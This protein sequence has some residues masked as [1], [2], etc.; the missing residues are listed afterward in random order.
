[1]AVLKQKKPD[2]I[3]IDYWATRE[4]TGKE[5]K[6]LD[7][8]NE[9]VTVEEMRIIDKQA[10]EKYGIPSIVLMENAG[11]TVAEETIKF[12]LSIDKLSSEL[13]RYFVFSDNYSIEYHYPRLQNVLI[14]IVC[15]N[16]NNGGDGFVAARHLYNHKL[17]TEIFL[18]KEKSHFKGDALKNLDIIFKIGLPVT[19]IN[20]NNIN[21]FKSVLK[22]SDVIIDSIFGIGLKDN[23]TGIYKDVI[24]IINE[25]KKPVIAVDV[26]SGFDSDKEKPLNVCVKATLTVTMHLPKKGMLSPSA[27]NFVGKIIIGNIGIPYTDKTI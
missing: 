20:N 16:G 11:R 7:C 6:Y 10:T 27:R 4:I 5:M 21:R 13:S 12:L 24:E 2:R 14:T 19:V 18:F 1:M 22:K 8:S 9:L 15:G 3:P 23:I 25:S 26:P 17:K